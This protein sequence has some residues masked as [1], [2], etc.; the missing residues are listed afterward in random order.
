MSVNN[1]HSIKINVLLNVVKQLCSILFP[2]ITIPYV[3][4]ILQ[5]ENLGKVNFSASIV[6]Y[7]AMIAQMGIANYAIR[8]G[9]KLRNKKNQIEEFSN[10]V[11]SFNIF[12]MMIAYILMFGFVYFCH[13]I[14]RYTLL[15][16]IHSATILFTTIGVDWVNNIYEDFFAITLRTII[17]QIVSLALMFIFVKKSSDYVVYATITVVA[18]C[19]AYLFNAFS[20]RKY[21]KIKVTFSREILKHLKPILFLFSNNI[22]MMVYINS[23]TTMIGF[24]IGDSAV[25]IYY[26]A[27]KMYTVIKNIINAIIVVA[28]PRLSNYVEHDKE[29]YNKLCTTVLTSV[30]TVLVPAVVGLFCCSNF[31]VK[32][33]AGQEFIGGGTALRILSVSLLFAIL[34]GFNTLCIVMPNREEKVLLLAT[35]IAAIVNIALNFVLIPIWSY[36]GAALTTVIAEA[37]VTIIT[38]IC[39]RK[40]ATIK[41][42]KNVVS[43]ISIGCI[44]IVISCLLTQRI[45]A[46]DFL[47]L[48]VSIVTS[49]IIYGVI[50]IV[51]K[52]PLIILAKNRFIKSL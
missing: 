6:S 46:N 9:A 15:L 12:T 2:L 26:I 43:S 29:A 32:I 4:R 10:E 17:M 37:I 38:Y 47:T 45:V 5:A 24:M 52:N 42:S 13:P 41:L 1:K 48:I 35:S 51:F 49:V 39:T 14:Q 34:G 33:I 20:I 7:F 36:N 50:L 25:A 19:G 31:I 16:I 23:D 21:V 30:L 44:F 40:Y 18:Q 27:T 22:A 28:L 11:F 3:T 8:E